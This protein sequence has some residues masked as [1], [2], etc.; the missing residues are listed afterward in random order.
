VVKRSG[1]VENKVEVMQLW[2]RTAATSYRPNITERLMALSAFAAVL[3]V[4]GIGLSMFT[5][6]KLPAGIGAVSLGLG[7]YNIWEYYAKLKV[8]E[9]EKK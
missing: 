5:G 6:K 3:S 9:S 7:L 2:G 1:E 4:I 8:L